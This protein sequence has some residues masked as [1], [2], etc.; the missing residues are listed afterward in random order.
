MQDPHP[1]EN[2]AEGVV[3][4]IDGIGQIHVQWD[5]GRRLALIPD[6]DKYELLD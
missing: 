4:F 5:N 3:D 1:I 2:G 6:Q